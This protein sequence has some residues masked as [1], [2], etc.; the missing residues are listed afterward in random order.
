MLLEIVNYGDAVLRQK[1]RP[2]TNV[3]ESIHVLA[4]N[5]LQTM[6]AA[7]GVGLAAP[8][9]GLPIQMAVVD[10]GSEEE[11]TTLVE[12]DGKPVTLGE[13]MPLVFINPELELLEP[14]EG[15]VEGCL[16]IPG[17][18]ANV[19]RHSIV[20]ANLELLDGRKIELKCNG[21]LARAIQHEC[22]HLNGVLFIDR[23]NSAQKM[24]LKKKLK[25]FTQ[26]RY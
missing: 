4:S 25:R 6:E 1:C 19:I 18:N 24:M 3:D 13:I 5:M 15:F 2:V 17:I 12:L 7:N 8:Q 23:L 11:S 26:R 22:D 20:V 14:L 9:I 10:I 21:L 16:S